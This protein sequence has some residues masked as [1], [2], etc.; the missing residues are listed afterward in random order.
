MPG[1]ALQTQFFLLINSLIEW[2][3]SNAL[4]PQQFETETWF[5]ESILSVKMTSQT[6]FF[7]IPLFV[8]NLRWCKVENFKQ[9]D[10]A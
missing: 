3:I 5:L 8:Q 1:A 6:N 4:I 2:H 9:V 10:F 7:L